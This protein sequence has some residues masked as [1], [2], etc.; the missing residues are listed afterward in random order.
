MVAAMKASDN[1]AQKWIPP[2]DVKVLGT[3]KYHGAPTSH[4]EASVGIVNGEYLSLLF[5]VSASVQAALQIP[6]NQRTP[7]QKYAVTDHLNE[8]LKDSIHIPFFMTIAEEFDESFETLMN[9]WKVFSGYT[10]TQKK[11]D[12]VHRVYAFCP[13]G[14]WYRPHKDYILPLLTRLRERGADLHLDFYS[15]A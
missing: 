8:P 3:A 9:E 15:G 11:N 6:H 13:P 14:D 4:C 5:P 2:G 12:P 10:H 1:D 7:S